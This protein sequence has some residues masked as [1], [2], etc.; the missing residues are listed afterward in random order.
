[1]NKQ[2]EEIS[3]LYDLEDRL[4]Q[5]TRKNSL[6]FHSIPESAYNLPEDTI[7]K[8]A[9]A[10]EVPV[11]PDDIG[12]SHKL[13]NQGNKAIIAKFIS[14][15]VKTKLYRARLNLKNIRL[16][17][18]FPN[19]SYAT[20]VESTQIFINEN[21]TSF[22]RLIMSRDGEVLSVWCMDRT[23]YVKTSTDRRPIKIN[24][25]GLDGLLI[26]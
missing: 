14:V 23:I 20:R 6:E 5:Y 12:I 26:R 10:L 1:M 21:L 9:E 18:H 3:E 19:S 15:K 11:S 13:N 22:R 24:E 25:L 17:D 7:L 4:E 16:A 2:E 8:I